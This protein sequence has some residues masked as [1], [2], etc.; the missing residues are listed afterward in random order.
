MQSLSQYQK[1]KLATW[2]YLKTKGYKPNGQVNLYIQERN[3]KPFCT[4]S[5]GNI[6]R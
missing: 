1:F 5:Q 4:F 3:S 6:R 2:N